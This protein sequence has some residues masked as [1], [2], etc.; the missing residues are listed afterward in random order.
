MGSNAG[1]DTELYLVDLL[2]DLPPQL[3][4]R[5]PG[6]EG[7]RDGRLFSYGDHPVGI[8]IYSDL[9]L[10]EMD[11]LLTGVDSS[12]GSLEW[13]G[14]TTTSESEVPVRVY[15]WVPPEWVGLDVEVYF[16]AYGSH[17][18]LYERCVVGESLVMRGGN[19]LGAVQV[20]RTGSEGTFD[21]LTYPVEVI[22]Y[23]NRQG[24]TYALDGCDAQRLASLVETPTGNLRIVRDL[25]GVQLLVVEMMDN[26]YN[27]LYANY[28]RKLRKRGLVPD[29]S[30]TTAIEE[31]S[32]YSGGEI[33]PGFYLT[34]TSGDPYTVVDQMETLANDYSL[35]LIYYSESGPQV[36]SAAITRDPWT[37]EWSFELSLGIVGAGPYRWVTEGG[38]VGLVVEETDTNLSHLTV[39]GR[40][41][42]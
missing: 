41:P 9:T 39:E 10:N 16:T 7:L 25:T 38:E 21:I 4:V 26:H 17:F 27:D 33:H 5:G 36:P 11:V 35:Y 42:G 29:Q 32:L 40:F 30:G 8:Q 15:W 19:W 13:D 34:S 22:D 18:P 37:G 28:L 20:E 2:A 3:V 14:D 1:T 23:I 24:T 6:L 12:G 31:R